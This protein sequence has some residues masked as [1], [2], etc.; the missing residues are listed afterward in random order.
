M[1]ILAHIGFALGIVAYCGARVVGADDG[2]VDRSAEYRA[3]DHDGV[4]GSVDGCAIYDLELSL[5]NCVPI[6]AA[7]VPGTVAVVQCES[8]W[9]TAA[10]GR[11]GERGIWQIH[12]IHRG[13]M[14]VGGLDY[15]SEHDRTIWAVNL[16]QQ[17]GWTPWS[18]EPRE[19]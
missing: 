8:R 14:A 15:G 3:Q 1:N 5:S 17:R 13:A 16:W 19:G 7:M 10:V 12:P 11:L 4:G 9:D 6:P 18:C 2:E